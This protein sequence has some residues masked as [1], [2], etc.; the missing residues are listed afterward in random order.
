MT[1]LKLIF[2][3]ALT[4]GL[5]AMFPAA[6]DKTS[7]NSTYRA[8]FAVY[9]PGSADTSV[10]AADVYIFGRPRDY[11][12]DWRDRGWR[13]KDFGYHRWD[14]R[15]WRDRS[16]DRYTYSRDR[17]G[18]VWRYDHY[19]RDWNLMPL[20]SWRDR[21]PY[22]HEPIYGRPVPPKR[23]GWRWHGDRDQD[24]RGDRTWRR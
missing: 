2:M 23:G 3:A 20:Y 6:A 16:F 9:Y 7:A 22:R 10:Q 17:F 24:W 4:V 1:P 8:D 13:D 12:R 11:D 19:T 15:D 18:R 21:G 14:R 5:L